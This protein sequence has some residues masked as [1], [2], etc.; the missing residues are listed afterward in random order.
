MSSETK[1]YSA[2][3]VA[4]FAW[5]EG[6]RP[7]TVSQMI[8]PMKYKNFFSKIVKT[9][10]QTPNLILASSNPGSGKTTLAK[11]IAEELGANYLYINASL[12]S[13]IE[14][15]RDD[16]VGFASTKSRGLSS[17]S[18]S[19]TKIIILDEFDFMS[20]T[21]QASLRG[22]I[23]STY[24][25]CRYI[26]TCNY[27][28]KIIPALREGRTMEFSFDMNTKE[29]RSECIPKFTA[30][31]TKMLEFKNITVTD[32]NIVSS[33]V[34]AYYPNARKM[35]SLFQKYSMMNNDIIDS[36]IL[37]TFG[38][39]DEVLYRSILSG[40]SESALELVVKQGY[41]PEDLYLDFY[42]NLMPMVSKEKVKD[43]FKIT[44]KYQHY[45]TSCINTELN[46]AGY[47]SELC[48]IF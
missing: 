46:F 45:H 19:L 10:K 15:I 32:P 30:Y 6:F 11:A 34:E 13:K 41:S 36:G 21:A 33:M 38:G 5:V 4:K 18:E 37:S 29:F 25:N 20:P 8:L 27:I 22:L 47:L 2:E 40:D 16:I 48:E 39:V 14:T 44:A 17:K 28:S 7:K 35:V 31:F 43:F 24:K 23:E 12:N 1:K 9:D 26:M 42:K 3:E